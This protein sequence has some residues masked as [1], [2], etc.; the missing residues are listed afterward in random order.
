MKKIVSIYI[1][2]VFLSVS[3]FAQTTSLEPFKFDDAW[4]QKIYTLAPGKTTVPVTKKHKV[5]LF[6]LF[7]GFEHWVIPHADAVIKILSEKTG[8]FE[9]V[10][11]EDI[12]MFE[13]KNLKKFDAIILNNNCSKGD[14]RNLFYDALLSNENMNEKERHEKAAELEKNLLSFV[15][16]GGGLMALHGAIVMQNK[17]QEISDMIGGSFDYHSKQQDVELQI[18]D[19]NH[20]MTKAFEGHSLTHY[21][22]PYFFN[23]AYF[24]KEFRPLLFMDVTKL[25][26]L[27]HKPK[28]KISYISWIKRYGKGRVFYVSPSHNAQ[29]YEDSRMLLFYLDGIQYVLGDLKCDDS[30]LAH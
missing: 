10:Q 15:E 22:E 30:P 19:V 13:K 29:S 17:S 3:T 6:S 14:N 12:M 26:S 5:L 7:T 25:H 20:P 21:D 24:K 23:N 9:V 11:S 18:S 27:K 4:K 2:L 16:K 8:A 1:I 28:E